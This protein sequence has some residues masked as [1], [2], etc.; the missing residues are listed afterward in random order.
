MSD[1]T[2]CDFLIRII[3]VKYTSEQI[4]ITDVTKNIIFDK[5]LIPVT[6]FLQFGC[7]E[8]ILSIFS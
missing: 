2:K 8:N 7:L 3:N 5:L 4:M 6:F 1:K